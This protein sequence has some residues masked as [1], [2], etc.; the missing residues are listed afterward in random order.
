MKSHPKYNVISMR[1]NDDE[2]KALRDITS[3]RKTSMSK[4][5]HDI[6]VKEISDGTQK[7]EE[8]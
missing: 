8:D 1:V 4:L 3:R 6:V 7:T 2:F 5:I